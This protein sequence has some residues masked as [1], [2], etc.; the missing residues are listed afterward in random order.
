M[1]D[2]PVAGESRSPLWTQTSPAEF[3]LTAGKIQNLR[4]AA[5]ALDGLEIPA[6]QVFSFWCQLGRTTRSKGF[7][8]GRELREGCLVPSTGGG[9]CQLSG[10]LYQA[11]LES[12]LEVVERHAHSRTVPGS[13][14]ERDRDATVFWNYVDLRFRAAFDWRLE[15]ELDA[16]HLVVRIRAAVPTGTKQPALRPADPPR[17]AATGDCL[18]CGQ[19]ECFR[20]PAATSAHAPS[21]GHSAFLLDARWPE[22]DRW[23]SG[24]SREGDRWF[25]PLDGHRWKKPNYAWSPPGGTPVQHATLP[26]LTRSFRQRRLPAQGAVRQAALLDADA[27]LAKYYADRISPECRHIVVSQNLLP[28]LWRLGAFGGRTFDVLVSRWPIADLHRHLDT[29]AKAQ[30][31]SPTL[32]DFR[33][34][35]DLVRDESVALDRAARLITPHRALA[36]HFGHRAWQ[37]EW[38]MPKA[39]GPRGTATPPTSLRLFL[40]C[41]ALGR[42][43]IHELAVALEGTDHELLILG[44]AREDASKDPLADI[45]WRQTSLD[46]LPNA[47]ALVLPAW[48]EHQPRLA[49]RALALGIPVIATEACG[50]PDHPLLQTLPRP[51]AEAL[52]GAIGS[53]AAPR[54][55]AIA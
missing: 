21:L 28:H 27:A 24:H 15:V 36:R 20:H 55:V 51:D 8:T 41:S 30:P 23:C 37:L 11:A 43:G 46:E 54:E 22:F 40:P 49:L 53:L 52:A 47:D 3:P 29:A 35:P 18:T 12:N 2:A 33:A 9:L 7:T 13:D 32:G 50:L 17:P 14:A 44:R 25:L 39:E 48:V 19:T 31:G 42:K 34:D 6:G 10:L 1:Q 5:L 38:D 16:T 4:L 45:N 26:T